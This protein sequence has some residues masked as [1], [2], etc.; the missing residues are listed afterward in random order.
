MQKLG[1]VDT[2]NL[3]MEHSTDIAYGNKFQYNADGTDW[4]LLHEFG[5]EWWANLVTASDWKDFWLHEGFQS[6]MDTLYQEYLHGQD[7]Y[8]SAMNNRVKGLENKQAVAPREAKIAYEAYMSA[9]EYVN[10]D[11]DI[12]GKRAL[13]LHTLRYLIGDEK[14]FNALPHI[15]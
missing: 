8:L 2:H 4:L 7:A 12:Y 13:I 6:Y 9:P 1:I 3:G 14:V 15:A 5:H 10:S 11:G